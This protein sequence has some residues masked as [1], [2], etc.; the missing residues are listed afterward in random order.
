[1][2]IP[3]PLDALITRTGEYGPVA[4]LLT[5]GAADPRPHVSHVAV[6]W[7]DGELVVDVGRSGTRNLAAV[8]AA[9]LLWPPVEPG[10]YS[11]IVDVV[12]RVAD[13]RAHLRPE[14][15]VLHRP[16]PVD[17]PPGEAACGQDCRPL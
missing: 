4:F 3:V 13:G 12:G 1:M 14:R 10:G 9:V 16:A 15:A 8:P 6:T 7:A 2:S 17:A 5:T 11:M